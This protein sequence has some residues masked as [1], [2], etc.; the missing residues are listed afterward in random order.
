VQMWDL[1]CREISY[2]LTLVEVQL[3][4]PHCLPLP[5]APSAGEGWDHGHQGKT[6]EEGKELP[7]SVPGD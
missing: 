2:Y 7:L 1:V 4:R 6:G 3:Q 5:R